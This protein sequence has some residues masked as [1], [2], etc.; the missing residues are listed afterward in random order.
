MV[1]EGMTG[2]WP[3][4]L[5]LALL[6]LA[7]VSSL[8][9]LAARWTDEARTYRH[10]ALAIDFEEWADLAAAHGGD[11]NGFLV[12]ARAAGVNLLALKEVTVGRLERS[13]QLEIYDPL[14]RPLPPADLTLPSYAPGYVYLRTGSAELFAALAAALP[15]RL[16]PGSVEAAAPYLAVRADVATVRLARGG[17]WSADLE[18]ASALGFELLLRPINLI[19]ADPASRLPDGLPPG[20][21]ILHQGAGVLGAPDDLAA[22]ATVMNDRGLVL[23]LLEMPLQLGIVEQDGIRDLA[24]LVDYRAVRVHAASEAEL[25]T[26]VPADLVDRSVRGARDRGIGVLYLKAIPPLDGYIGWAPLAEK[27]LEYYGG[28]ARDLVAQG[29]TI[30][31]AEA[32]GLA[33]GGP[34]ALAGLM[35]AA[36]AAFILAGALLDQVTLSRRLVAALLLAPLGLV[37]LAIL[38]RLAGGADLMRAALAFAVA[39]L[40]PAAAIVLL[41]PAL[42]AAAGVTTAR[43]R[44]WLGVRALLTATAVGIGSGLLVAATLSGPLYTLEFAYFRGVKA[45]HII[46]PVIALLLGILAWWRAQD[47]GRRL[48]AS[49]LGGRILELLRQPLTWAAAGLGVGVAV[50]FL[51]ILG[52]SGHTAGY[53]VSVYEV[54]LRELFD[55]KLY[56]RPRFKEILLGHPALLYLAWLGLGPQKRWGWVFA[57]GLGAASIGQLSV[58]NSFSHLRTAVMISLVRSLNGLWVGILIAAAGLVVLTVAARVGRWLGRDA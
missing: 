56:A 23:G 49:R 18:M 12:Q 24:R 39:A 50:A 36:G 35:G 8:P 38:A 26:L 14:T 41:I 51:L 32:N 31:P 44:W 3:R 20:T 11:I 27:G 33:D 30:G 7:L 25:K 2:K 10:V 55:V 4:S 37:P 46:P 52:R 57:G 15:G 17:F 42:T 5:G 34:G 43:A 9:Y 45:A 40:A 19:G 47:G 6:V 58:V 53:Q 22:A 48:T 16:A 21:V 13:G 1:F 54:A 28:L 29:Y